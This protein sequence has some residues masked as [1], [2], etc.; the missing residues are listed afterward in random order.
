MELREQSCLPLILWVNL[1]IHEMFKYFIR[2]CICLSRH[3]YVNEKLAL[4]A[5]KLI[6]L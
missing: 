5:N 3:E 1:Q 4:G 6:I 2:F